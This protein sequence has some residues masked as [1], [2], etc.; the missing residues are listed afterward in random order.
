MQASAIQFAI[1]VACARAA[2][3]ASVVSWLSPFLSCIAMF[4]SA[5]TLP[6]GVSAHWCKIRAFEKIE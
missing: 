6:G 2:L 4:A 1:R 3:C 5:F